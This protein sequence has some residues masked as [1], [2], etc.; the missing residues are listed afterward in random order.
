LKGAKLFDIGKPPH[1]ALIELAENAN[2]WCDDTQLENFATQLRKGIKDYCSKDGVE[3]TPMNPPH[4]QTRHIARLVGREEAL[5]ATFNSLKDVGAD[6]VFVTLHDKDA[7]LYEALKYVAEVKY[8]IH[9]I[10]TVRRA[11][12]HRNEKDD[13]DRPTKQIK[14]DGAFIA[15]L[16]L[17]CNRNMGR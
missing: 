13:D 17:R 6:V 1:W 14:T 9:T 7:A 12:W 10:C 16:I 5:L 4:N 3:T 2:A 15:N 11:E 8:G